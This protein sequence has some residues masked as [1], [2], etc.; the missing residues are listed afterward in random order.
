MLLAHHLTSSLN[1]FE[2]ASLVDTIN[3]P[4]VEVESIPHLASGR[5]IY[6]NVSIS[7]SRCQP[8]HPS[9][10]YHPRQKKVETLKSNIGSWRLGIYFSGR[11]LA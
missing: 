3:S 4:V 11:V 1:T 9:P 8:F 2:M 7:E 10:W 5:S 6:A